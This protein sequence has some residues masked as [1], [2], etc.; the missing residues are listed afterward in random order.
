MTNPLKTLFA[1]DLALLLARLP[2]GAYFFTAGF[3]KVFDIGPRVFADK[4]LGL[5][6]TFLPSELG[7]YYLT[8]LPFVEVLAGLMLIL[9][10]LGRLAGGLAF[11]MLLSITIAVGVSA[12]PEPNAFVAFFKDA[13]V[14]GRP[15]HANFIFLGVAFVVMVMGSGGFSVDRFLFSGGGKP[16][17]G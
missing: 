7:R 14:P 2:L 8:A 15:F 6:P 5:W 3:N 4:N 9:G 1:E 17:K 11:L 10:F 16:L 13:A 12:R